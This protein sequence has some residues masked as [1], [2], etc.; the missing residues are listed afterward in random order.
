MKVSKV[1]LGTLLVKPAF[2]ALRKKIQMAQPLID[3]MGT[4]FSN[5][6][7]RIR[8]SRIINESAPK[9]LKDKTITS[10]YPSWPIGLLNYCGVLNK[11]NLQKVIWFLVH[12]SKVKIEVPNW[13]Q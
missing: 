9:V 5:S 1:N 4:G 12:S 7:I 3:C 6:Q 8:K 2:L 10:R 11:R 13:V